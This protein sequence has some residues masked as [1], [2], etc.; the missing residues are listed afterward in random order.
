MPK[1]PGSNKHWS[2]VNTFNDEFPKLMRWIAKYH[3]KALK[4]LG[5]TLDDETASANLRHSAAK[6]VNNM[7]IKYFKEFKGATPKDFIP[8][9]TDWEIHKKKLEKEKAAGVTPLLQTEYIP[10]DEDTG[11]DG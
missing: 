9:E 5:D 2:A 1:P 7:A 11:T 10:E 4:V 8:K 3:S 6:E